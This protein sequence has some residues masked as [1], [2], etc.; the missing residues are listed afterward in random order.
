VTRGSTR[1]SW[2][3]HEHH[4]DFTAVLGYVSIR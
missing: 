1:S 4:K 3:N 2:R